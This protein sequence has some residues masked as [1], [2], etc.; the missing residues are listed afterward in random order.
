[1]R[2][3]YTNACVP[4]YHAFPELGQNPAL[5]V[6]YAYCC[7]KRRRTELS[8]RKV[9]DN[10]RAILRLAGVDLQPTK[11]PVTAKSPSALHNWPPSFP[12]IARRRRACAQR[13]R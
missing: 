2:E 11:R 12:E 8:Q 13:H 4:L 5:P 3:A 1:M 10:A 6:G 7:S 9:V